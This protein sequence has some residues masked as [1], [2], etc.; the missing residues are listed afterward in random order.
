MGRAISGDDIW[1][2]FILQ[3]LDF[4]LQKEFFLL[5]ALY[6]QSVSTRAGFKGL[7]GQIKVAMLCSQMRKLVANLSFFFWCH[8]SVPSL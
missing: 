5:H 1:K 8:R 2:K 4:V 6:R 7:N 3:T